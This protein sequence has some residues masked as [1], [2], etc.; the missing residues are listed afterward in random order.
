MQVMRV[1]NLQTKLS[2]IA[3]SLMQSTY[4]LHFKGQS[5]QVWLAKFAHPDTPCHSMRISAQKHCNWKYLTVQHILRNGVLKPMKA[6][7]FVDS[8]LFHSKCMLEEGET[9]RNQQ[10]H[11]SVS[12][13]NPGQQYGIWMLIFAEFSSIIWMI[14]VFKDGWQ[15]L[16]SELIIVCRLVKS[17][18]RHL[19]ENWI[20][21]LP[22]WLI[23]CMI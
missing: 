13:L 10:N 3:P 1:C 16:T 2:S 11:E 19:V 5:K 15:P 17:L 6:N 20:D 9:I 21:F 23:F 22:V 7:L 12:Q 8:V 4:S 18:I 14:R